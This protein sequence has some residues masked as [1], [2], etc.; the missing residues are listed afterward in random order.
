MD[1]PAAAAAATQRVLDFTYEIYIQDLRLTDSIQLLPPTSI[2][3]LMLLLLLLWCY[4]HSC[5]CCCCCPALFLL[6][7]SNPLMQSSYRLRC[8]N[9]KKKKKKKVKNLNLFF[10]GWGFTTCAKYQL[11][12]AK[13]HNNSAVV[14]PTFSHERK[15]AV[16]LSIENWLVYNKV[17]KKTGGKKKRISFWKYSTPKKKWVRWW[18]VSNWE[19]LHSRQWTVGWD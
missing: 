5:C 9:R 7:H 6:F 17:K 10:L 16:R 8:S 15:F 12:R 18:T 2:I 14:F 11:G 1:G 19:S 3:H 4:T 13:W